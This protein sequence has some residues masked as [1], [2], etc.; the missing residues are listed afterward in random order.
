M[1]CCVALCQDRNI[2]KSPDETQQQQFAAKRKRL[3]E[4][5]LERP[6]IDQLHGLIDDGN[7]QVSSLD[8]ALRSSTSIEMKDDSMP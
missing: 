5:L 7:L 2:L 3:S 6:T 1:P 4:F 8:Q